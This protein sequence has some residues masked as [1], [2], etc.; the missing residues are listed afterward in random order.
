MSDIQDL[1]VYKNYLERIKKS[2]SMKNQS[3]KTRLFL[4]VFLIKT[5]VKIKLLTNKIDH[6]SI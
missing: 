2:L 5:T 3:L 4:W 6:E 1:I